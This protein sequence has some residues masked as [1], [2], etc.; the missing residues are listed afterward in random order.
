[1]RCTWLGR[2]FTPKWESVFTHRSKPEICVRCFDLI[3]TS[4]GEI[5]IVDSVIRR[6]LHESTRTRRHA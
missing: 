5:V 6:N 3:R 4:T 2:H 1:M